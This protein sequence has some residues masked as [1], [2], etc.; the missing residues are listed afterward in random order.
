M[1][2][3]TFIHIQGIGEKTEK[4]IWYRGIHTWADFLKCPKVLSRSKDRFIREELEKS[5]TNRKEIGYFLER[6]PSAELWRLYS[7]F[8]NR[9]V[10]LDIETCGGYM[11]VDEITVIGM[12]DGSTMRSF[13]S[14]MDLGDFERAISDFDV[15]VTFNGTCFDVPF[16]RRFFPN[17]T[18]PSAHVDLRY[19]LRK[20]GYR[21]GLK[22][23]EKQTGMI[24]PSEIDGLNGYDAVRLWRAYECGDSHALDVLLEYNK[25]D[26][27]NLAVL[28]EMANEELKA[29]ILS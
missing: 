10:Y 25:A 14:G 18:L 29:R 23:I 1:L 22:K 5:I 20:L 27:M 21:G 28:M 16:I 15:M 8:K 6:L 4:A 11:G 24:R 7:S 2:E 12:Y 17:I 26:V 19:A 13:V 3:H 9:L